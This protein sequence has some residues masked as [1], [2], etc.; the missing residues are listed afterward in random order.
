MMSWT[1]KIQAIHIKNW[2]NLF[3]ITMKIKDVKRI[4]LICFYS[5]PLEEITRSFAFSF[6]LISIPN[7]G[8]SVCTRKP[9]GSMDSWLQLNS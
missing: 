3:C 1:F 8:L 4:D 2:E 6:N 5:I 9:R 7:A